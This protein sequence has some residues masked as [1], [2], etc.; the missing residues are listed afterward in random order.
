MTMRLSD[1]PPL[2]LFVG[3]FFSTRRAKS[4]MLRR[5]AVGDGND[6]VELREGKKRCL[7]MRANGWSDEAKDWSYEA[8]DWG[9]RK[10]DH[11]L[12]NLT[13]TPL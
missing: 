9:G 3:G 8:K 7:G 11:D 6:I 13:D 2:D 10:M 4:N 1:S 5:T 12:R